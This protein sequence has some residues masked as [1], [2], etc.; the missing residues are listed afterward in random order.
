[1]VFSAIME[2][3]ILLAFFALAQNFRGIALPFSMRAKFT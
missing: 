1:M 2:K 3:L